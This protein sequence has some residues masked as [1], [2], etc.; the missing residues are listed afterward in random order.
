MEVS[1][2]VCVR[3]AWIW[4]GRPGRGQIPDR[5][6]QIW[7]G[8]T[9][10]LSNFARILIVPNLL[11]SDRPLELYSTH[12]SGDPSWSGHCPALSTL[13]RMACLVSMHTI[14]T[15]LASNT[16]HMLLCT[17]TRP[18]HSPEYVPL[19]CTHDTIPTTGLKHVIHLLAIP[20]PLFTSRSGELSRV[21]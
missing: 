12:R 7:A 20:Y 18:Q 5:F 2:S 1:A 6:R 14:C 8:F 3:G 19:S 17:P 4:T 15:T 11:N 10:N 21:L 13:L 16:P 9:A